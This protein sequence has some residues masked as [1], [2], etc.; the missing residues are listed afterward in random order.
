MAALYRM[1]TISWAN[2]MTFIEERSG[3][4]CCS[5]SGEE[6]RT[7]PYFSW[8]GL[9]SPGV[10]MVRAIARYGKRVALHMTR[11]PMPS[12]NAH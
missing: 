1:S 9:K 11:F 6:Q 8:A 2:A 10:L 4:K 3:A 12:R 7:I 5:V